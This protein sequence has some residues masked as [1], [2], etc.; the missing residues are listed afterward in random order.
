MAILPGINSSRTSN[1]PEGGIRMVAVNYK[2][3][4]KEFTAGMVIPPRITSS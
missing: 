2:L 4:E 3:L 1:Q